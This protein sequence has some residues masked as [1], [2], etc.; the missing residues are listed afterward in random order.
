MKKHICT[1][2]LALA[3]SGAAV[4]N[5]VTIVAPL[6]MKPLIDAASA[7][8]ARDGGAK[9]TLVVIPGAEIPNRLKGGTQFDVV[10]APQAVIRELAQ[11]GAV[12]EGQRVATGY[13]VVAHRRGT[14]KPDASTKEAFR[15][16]LLK[17][18]RISTSDPALGGVTANLLL[19]VMKEMAI[20]ETVRPKLV[21]TK[22]GVSAKPVEDD[23]ADIAITQASE[24]AGLKNVDSVPL[25]SGDPRSRIEFFAARRPTAAPDAEKFVAYLNS[26]KIVAMKG[27]LGL[28]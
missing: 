27:E 2:S 19:A 17:A 11:A 8:Y 21:L 15:D 7:G 28:R 9:V 16:V 3:L 14:P 1:L 25:L 23:Q 10:I 26:E 18:Q 5:E 20:E 24:L 4:A 6:P 12:G 22:P 13:A